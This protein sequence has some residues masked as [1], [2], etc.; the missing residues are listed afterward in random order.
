MNFHLY[1]LLITSL[2]SLVYL[3]TVF[4]CGAARGK[5]KIQA[6]AVTGHIEFEKRFRIQQNTMEQLILFYPS[7]WVFSLTVSQV[8]GAILGLLFIVG[9]IVY[10]IGYASDPEK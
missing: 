7:L 10:A 4:M 2:A 1:P 6:P 3:W 5:Y 8:W 9:R